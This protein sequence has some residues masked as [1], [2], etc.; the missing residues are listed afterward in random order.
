MTTSKVNAPAVPRV[1]LAGLSGRMPAVIVVSGSL[2]LAVVITIV[3][4]PTQI[5]NTLV[6]GGMWALMSMGLALIFGV[7]NIPHLPTA[8]PSWWAL[9]WPISSSRR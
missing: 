1:A 5:V 7:M 3:A 6:T 8:S 9:S 4:G 2:V